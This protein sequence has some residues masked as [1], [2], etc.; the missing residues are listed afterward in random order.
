MTQCSQNVKTTKQII[1]KATR[2]RKL[3]AHRVKPIR[4]LSRN[5]ESQENVEHYTSGPENKQP[6]IK[7]IVSIR[8]LKTKQRNK[9]NSRSA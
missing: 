9:E 2:E 1:L 7:I 8:Y 3:P 5:P 4:V 6:L